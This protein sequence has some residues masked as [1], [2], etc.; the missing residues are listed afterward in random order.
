LRIF[1]KRLFANAH[2]PTYFLLQ[3]TAE[4]PIT[5]ISEDILLQEALQL[6]RSKGYH[7]TSMADIAEKCG[8]LKGSI[9]HY[10]PSKEALMG[11]LLEN[12]L[13]Y[14]RAKAFTAAYDE[15]RTPAERMARFL[16]VAGRFYKQHG[17]ACL[18]GTTGLSTMNEDPA[19]R[20]IILEFFNEWMN[21][22]EAIYYDQYKR[23]ARQMAEQ[24]VA[25]LEGGILL[26]CLMKDI[27]Y[28]NQA[29]ERV[30]ARLTE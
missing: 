24:S 27:R 2:I 22:F 1:T 13:K 14:F 9:Y 10:Y 4:V 5:K 18:M 3:P 6:F 19:F 28:W 20:T 25:E 16:E 26:M 15:R 29:V 12:V 8:I 23:E 30:Q 17:Q 11:K 7:A 21:A